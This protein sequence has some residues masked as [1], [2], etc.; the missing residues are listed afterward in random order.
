[1]DSF[2]ALQFGEPDGQFVSGFVHLDE[3][4]PDFCSVT[5]C[6]VCSCVVD[7]GMA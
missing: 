1:M 2:K 7:I 6:A 5:R 4:R 3:S